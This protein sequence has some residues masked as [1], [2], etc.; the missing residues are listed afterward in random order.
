[1]TSIKRLGATLAACAVASSL[2]ACSLPVGANV[3]VRATGRH[4]TSIT[5]CQAAASRGARIPSHDAAE[6]QRRIPQ[7]AG[8]ERTTTIDSQFVRYSLVNRD[9][10]HDAFA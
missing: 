1:M 2:S 5:Q 4:D 8:W 7:P 10:I 6:P 9:L 3:A